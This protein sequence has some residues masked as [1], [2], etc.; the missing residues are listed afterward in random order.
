MHACVHVQEQGGAEGEGERE[1]QA[2]SPLSMKPDT[3]L[4]FTMLRS[5]LS[6]N[7]ESD[8]LINCATQAASRLLSGYNSSCKFSL[9]T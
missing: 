1:S 2:D 9:M 8:A 3:G 7:Q 4:C 5:D 6:R